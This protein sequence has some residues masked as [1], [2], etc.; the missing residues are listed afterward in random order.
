MFLMR[1]AG[2]RRFAVE[3]RVCIWV[4]RRN[5]SVERFYERADNDGGG[6]GTKWQYLLTIRWTT[7]Y[8]IHITIYIVHLYMTYIFVYII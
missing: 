2:G 1:G 3:M 7:F 6:M 4:K 5:H 8:T